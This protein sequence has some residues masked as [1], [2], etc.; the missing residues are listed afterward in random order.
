M[1]FY[2]LGLL[3]W[4]EADLN[5]SLQLIKLIRKGQGLSRLNDAEGIRRTSLETSLSFN[6]KIEHYS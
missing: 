5:V 1:L 3:I 2:P 6:W 4:I